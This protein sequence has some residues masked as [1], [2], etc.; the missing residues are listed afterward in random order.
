MATNRENNNVADYF[1]L[2]KRHQCCIEFCPLKYSFLSRGQRQGLG[3][4]K[5]FIQALSNCCF[6]YFFF[7]LGY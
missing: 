5:M 7:K 6:T 4:L 1:G 2:C 3:Y